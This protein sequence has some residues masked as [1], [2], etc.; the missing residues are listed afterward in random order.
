MW[1]G[2]WRLCCV[3][4]VERVSGCGDREH[5]AGLRAVQRG[6]AGEALRDN[7]E[8]H[9][10]SLSQESMRRPDPGQLTWTCKKNP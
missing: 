7:E 6:A 3:I 5:G 8:K 1:T 2:D 10:T 4:Q 9:D